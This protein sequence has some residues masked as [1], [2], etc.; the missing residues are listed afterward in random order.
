MPPYTFPFLNNQLQPT[1]AECEEDL[2]PICPVCLEP[3]D[4]S[5]TGL[6][7]ILCQ[8]TFHCHCLSKWGDGSC[9]VCRYSQKPAAAEGSNHIESH[10]STTA[11][12]SAHQQ[13]QSRTQERII[14]DAN[15]ENECT[16]CKS[17]ENLWVCLICG[18]I[19]CGR[20]VGAHAYEHYRETSH[21]YSL[22][23]D[24]QRVWD[25]TGDG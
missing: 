6:L 18:H 5:N 25:Y 4:E 11:A 1:T 9:P 14:G 7:T 17:T 8:H 3:M 15:D 21:L 13:Q 2:L 22:E 16:I 10:K 23:I 24:T 20:Y 12:A 19:G